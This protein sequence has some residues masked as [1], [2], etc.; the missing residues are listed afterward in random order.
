MPIIGR[1]FRF[2]S[3][4]E[5]RSELLI[6]MTPYVVRED[7]DADVLKHMESS[8]MSWALADVVE[9]HGDAGLSPGHGLWGEGEPPAI[10]PKTDPLTATWRFFMGTGVPDTVVPPVVAPVRLWHESPLPDL[11]DPFDLRYQLWPWKPLAEPRGPVLNRN[12]EEPY[13][14]PGPADFQAAT[15]AYEVLPDAPMN[16]GNMSSLP[17][18]APRYGFPR[19]QE[20]PYETPSSET[21]QYSLP[22][23]LAPENGSPQGQPP[24]PRSGGANQGAS[25]NVPP[26]L[27]APPAGTGLTNGSS[28]REAQPSAPVYSAHG[29][30]AVSTAQYVDDAV[31]G[32]AAQQGAV[33]GGGAVV[34]RRLFDDRGYIVEE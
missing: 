18:P 13:Y 11:L 14:A 1:I 24:Q 27:I 19:D 8:R 21:P 6:I 26:V 29:G 16:D 9:L 12:R 5:S 4:V 32:A 22:Q 25:S 10:F 17:A 20:R 3:E 23:G 7:H 34:T 15:S 30:G 33:G 2:D 31:L 28:R